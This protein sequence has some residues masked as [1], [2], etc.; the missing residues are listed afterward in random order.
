MRIRPGL[1][2]LVTCSKQ[3]VL[4]L[5]RT[6]V[7]LLKAA[8]HAPSA[9][10]FNSYSES[11]T[12]SHLCP[13]HTQIIKNSEVEALT[14]WKK[15]MQSAVVA[16]SQ[17]RVE[18]AK[19]YFSASLEVTLMR[20]SQTNVQISATHLL[21]PVH[22]LCEIYLSEDQSDSAEELYV[23]ARKVLEVN[24]LSFTV[25]DEKIMAQLSEK[26]CVERALSLGATT[27]KKPLA[28]NVTVH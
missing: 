13:L 6:R 17:C 19:T 24:T 10:L 21:K 25:E 15:L 22:F 14:T 1:L 26:C 4:A 3:L 11:E 8:L 12:M 9:R 18:A 7:N 5:A 2:V 28:Q 23:F 20:L 27:H 16:F